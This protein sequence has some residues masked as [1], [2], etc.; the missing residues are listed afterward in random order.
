MLRPHT[1]VMLEC[2]QVLFPTAEDTSDIHGVNHKLHAIRI[3]KPSAA[4]D[5]R[6]NSNVSNAGF[7]RCAG[8]CMRQC[9]SKGHCTRYG[10]LHPIRRGAMPTDRV[11]HT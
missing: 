6:C 8:N 5:K 1:R 3:P 11:Q 4:F 7:T 9:I 2:P 10:T